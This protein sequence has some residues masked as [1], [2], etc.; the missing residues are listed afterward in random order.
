MTLCNMRN[1]SV[2]VTY[3]LDLL[4]L[5]DFD[6][7]LANKKPSYGK[8]DLKNITVNKTNSVVW[9]PYP[10][11][12][13]KKG[14]KNPIRLRRLKFYDFVYASSISIIMCRDH[15]EISRKILYGVYI[16]IPLIIQ[17]FFCSLIAA[18]IIWFVERNKNSNIK[19]SFMEGT[20]ISLW[21][22]HV[23]ITTTGYGDIVPVTIIDRLIASVWIIMG[24]F[25][26]SIITAAITESVV[27]LSSLNIFEES[28]AVLKYSHEEC[29]AIENYKG[30]Q[31][32][33]KAYESY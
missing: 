12:L 19:P 25:N 27:G 13:R 24:I 16:C 1:Y 22:S 8:K 33:V 23:T 29:V 20:G 26:M 28:I 31:D 7:I 14:E 5:N 21:W 2:N 15:I 32:D 30:N 6:K 10:V 18:I 11:S 9:F 4:T 17:L 3:S